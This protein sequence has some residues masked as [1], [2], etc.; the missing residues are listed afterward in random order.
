MSIVTKALRNALL[1]AGLALA[2]VPATV[3]LSG[4]EIELV[5]ML[6]RERR[7]EQLLADLRD[8]YELVLIDCPPSLGLLTINA[9]TAADAVVIPLQCEY[10]ALEGLAGLL[11]TV[12][13]VR[14]Q[15]NPRLSLEG[16]LFTM[17]DLRN[18]L[19]KQVAAEVR[20][21]FAERVFSTVIPRNVRLSEAPSHGKPVLLYDAR[22]RGAVSYLQ[23]AEEMLV[24]IRRP[25]PPLEPPTMRVASQG[26]RVGPKVSGSVVGDSPSSGVLVLPT[27]TKP[28]LQATRNATIARGLTRPDGSERPRVRGL[29][30]SKRRSARRLKAMAAERAK[31]MASRIFTA[32]AGLGS[33]PRVPSNRPITAKGSEKSKTLVRHIVMA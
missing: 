20:G 16:I 18:N 5:S 13:L 9:L 30:A 19:A 31:T 4:A 27:T 6:N 10:Y 11:E 3:A 21:H 1:S 2:V 33:S 7:V 23:L 24:R 14:E 29:L 8:S 28:A 26:L 22:S 12:D 15:L 17:A 25:D 32:S